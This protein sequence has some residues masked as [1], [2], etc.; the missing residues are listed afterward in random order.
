MITS[1]I[2]TYNK[3]I[4]IDS[5]IWVNKNKT[6]DDF[7]YS[8]GDD[9]EKFI[10]EILKVTDDLSSNS[11]ELDMKWIDWPSEYHL[12]SRRANLI[13]AIDLTYA[14][15]AL[16]IGSGCGAITRY[17]GESDIHV[18]AVEGSRRRAEITRLRCRDLDRINVICENF[19]SL[20]IP[21]KA[22][23][24]VLLIGVMEY[25]ERFS[26]FST[27]HC[28]AVT[29]ILE[30]AK[31]A[32]TDNGI[33][34]IA[35]ENRLGF[36]YLFGA[37][38][39]HYGVPYIGVY[40]YPEYKSRIT[41][42]KKG[43]RT[44]DKREWEAIMSKLN[45]LWYEFYY[46]FPDYKLPQ[47]VLSDHFA[48][49]D[50]FA[51]SNLSRINSRDYNFFWSPCIDEYLFWETAAGAGYLNASSNSF[52]IVLSKSKERIENTIHFDF[53]HFPNPKRK[54]GFRAVTV[55][56][57]GKGQ[58]LKKRIDIN[59]ANSGTVKFYHLPRKE[60]YL[61]GHLLSDI[62]I[63]ALKMLD[64]P[65]IFE[66]LIENYYH[67]LV[68]HF[69]KSKDTSMLI[70][71]M[72]FNIIVDGKGHY[73]SFDFEWRAAEPI[74]PEFV[75]FRSI[76]Y[77][78]C[79]QKKCLAQFFKGKNIGTIKD[80]ITYC[81]IL[82][83]SDVSRKLPEFIDQENKFQ[84]HVLLPMAYK[85]VEDRLELD[86][87]EEE[88]LPC[89]AFYPKLYWTGEDGIFREEMSITLTA[90]L[91]SVRQKLV[92]V[93]PASTTSPKKIRFDPADH[94]L[95]GPN[96]L[97]NLFMVSLL[98]RTNDQNEQIV[99]Q[100]KGQKEINKN[101]TIKGVIGKNLNPGEAFLITSNDPQ[102]IFDIPEVVDRP[103]SGRYVVE[104]EISWQNS[105]K[106]RC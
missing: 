35:I 42:R 20:N 1:P 19:N 102:I 10:K 93:L 33:I 68:E 105:G 82:V 103:F 95:F 97:F 60:K 86:V 101:V 41:D 45:G 38:E 67:F 76:L 69:K 50:K 70:D 87:F 44:Y 62:W 16:E 40:G 29:N 37:S 85:S 88:T 30:K 64:D 12:S 51:F 31:E 23:D 75:F 3:L 71:L 61:Q 7:A 39:D 77:F 99:W 9:S 36:K 56:P 72:P 34:L 21:K 84:T 63:R 49:S 81:F 106:I 104:V 90:R 83:S 96:K 52:A 66:G 78:G 89:I 65:K 55:K 26:P 2:I 92:F 27:S 25:A 94:T 54:P 17:L 47:V 48:E 18:D 98:W 24:A 73:N 15:T 74:T 14:R 79:I 22:Y 13:R 53:V 5:G 4:R 11:L 59:Q 46:P 58:I 43:I 6:N 8:D 91:E 28:Q 57:R 32:V 100:L 80:F